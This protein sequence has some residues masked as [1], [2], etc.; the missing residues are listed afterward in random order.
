MVI[1]SAGVGYGDYSPTTTASKGLII[2]SILFS[3]IMIPPQINDLLTIISSKSNYKRPYKPS[4]NENH[5]ILCGNV[6]SKPKLE[7][8]FKE[9]FHPDRMFSAGPEY[10]VVILCPNE[11]SE[12]VKDLFISSMLDSRVTYVVG[13]ALSVEDLKKVRAD[14]ASGMFFIC[15]TEGSMEAAK[16]EDATTVM[17]MLSVSN[18]NPDVE[19]YVQ[20]IRP[21]DRTILK[22]SDVEFILCLDEFKTTLIARNSICPGF[23]T[24]IEN[25]FHTFG[26]ISEEE[27]NKL[28][29]WYSEYLHGA[30]MEMYYVPLDQDFLRAIHFDFDKLCEAV[31][32]EFGIV[33]LA[34]CNA[35]QD[36]ITFNPN[37]KDL[38]KH[39]SFKSFFQEF[40]V[41]LI[42]ADDN[43]QAEEIARGLSDPTVVASILQKVELAEDEFSVRYFSS[44]KNANG[45]D[46]PGDC[47][48]KKRGLK[49]NR[50]I[51]PAKS[52]DSNARGMPSQ[53]SL[54]TAAL[55][56]R[57][58]PDTV[59]KKILK[60]PADDFDSDESDPEQNYIGFRKRDKT[61]DKAD[62]FQ[63]SSIV[64]TKSHDQTP[65]ENLD[66]GVKIVL[67]TPSSA[68]RTVRSNSI[69]HKIHIPLVNS[70]QMKDGSK[71]ETNTRAVRKS[72]VLPSLQKKA[73]NM[74]I[75][76]SIVEENDSDDSEE[77]EAK[78]QRAELENIK[79][80]EEEKSFEEVEDTSSKLSSLKSKFSKSP[81]ALIHP[82]QDPKTRQ[83]ELLLHA[84]SLWKKPSKSSE[85][86]Q[87]IVLVKPTDLT[88]T[89]TVPEKP[90]SVPPE[91]TV[92][93]QAV[94]IS[95][96]PSTPSSILPELKNNP[97]V[98]DLRSPK[99]NATPS[100]PRR[101]SP[102]RIQPT[103]AESKNILIPKA[104]LP[105]I[106]IEEPNSE[107]S[108]SQN[109][110][111]LK[112]IPLSG[113][114]IGLVSSHVMRAKKRET[115]ISVKK[116]IYK[117]SQ[118]K[119]G[120]D[121]SSNY[122]DPATPQR[123][124]LNEGHGEEFKDQHHPPNP[125]KKNTSS[126][127][128]QIPSDPPTPKEAFNSD[129]HQS[130]VR[131]STDVKKSHWKKLQLAI[132]K[133]GDKS[134]DKQ[135]SSSLIFRK[136]QKL[137]LF[138]R[139]L[140]SFKKPL[141]RLSDLIASDS[142]ANQ[143]A[144]VE[145]ESLSPTEKVDKLT[146]GNYGLFSFQTLL[147]FVGLESKE[148]SDLFDINNHII[149]FGNT[150]NLPMFIPE[151]R[152]PSVRGDTYH[153][154]VVVSPDEPEKWNAIKE[155]YN[156]VYFLRGSLTRTATFNKANIDEAF[157]VILFC[158]RDEKDKEVVRLLILTF[159]S[160]FPARC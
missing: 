82:A 156:D 75:Q 84:A 160:Y 111:E 60:H 37:R 148:V 64:Y 155:R 134:T 25:I 63:R 112:N 151:L 150:T 48:S 78:E 103:I 54:F 98:A 135:K 120:D 66:G 53:N 129:R 128:I 44:S 141:Q 88:L 154:L 142:N 35:N 62:E 41:A 34:L 95:S 136:S 22:D 65:S 2:F 131:H 143:N 114:Q 70:S 45:N 11:P 159:G 49:R 126:P 107:N 17:R 153:P 40:N 50:V 113:P 67:N 122:H 125:E 29:P 119:I 97:T 4:R 96:S 81:H 149:V 3:V 123:N 77:L 86:L 104:E 7:Q 16:I 145:E 85:N 139:A 92:N 27:E 23:S 61:K 51:T 71:P 58:L 52:I 89:P 132:P 56:T 101:L 6:N 110:E 106:K 117:E 93:Q 8:F 108:K 116:V 127:S 30:R 47:S 10:H 14:V 140:N 19:C 43:N 18:F 13:S 21:E 146:P 68:R 1:T 90:V 147:I 137:S 158:H 83:D 152:R 12:A 9:F 115:K 80:Q 87:S 69:L 102:L 57:S 42:I 15:N 28:A 91:S 138:T 36:S 72:M 157:A 130:P 55:Q 20:V 26:A 124:S 79:E 5:I 38:G 33:V 46:D 133:N 31:Y 32:I 24:F 109:A 121:M 100:R 94:E 99:A 144:V 59:P 73:A 105:P 74:N 39:R 76:Q 118:E